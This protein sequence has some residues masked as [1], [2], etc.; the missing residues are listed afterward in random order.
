MVE[1]PPGFQEGREKNREREKEWERKEATDGC[2]GEVNGTAELLQEVT[3]VKGGGLQA[4]WSVHLPE[5]C[6]LEIPSPLRGQQHQK[7]QGAAGGSKRVSKRHAGGRRVG[8]TRRRLGEAARRQR[9]ESV[10][11]KCKAEQPAARLVACL[12][13]LFLRADFFGICA[14]S[15]EKLARSATQSSAYICRKSTQYLGYASK[16]ARLEWEL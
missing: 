6:A 15:L 8:V 11:L 7:A 10:K 16:T 1:A 13:F 9:R 3:Q 5:E 14:G 2:S 12:V 4:P